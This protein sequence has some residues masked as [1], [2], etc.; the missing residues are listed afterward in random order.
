MTCLLMWAYNSIP[1][2]LAAIKRLFTW[3]LVGAKPS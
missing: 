2:S 1:M 3:K